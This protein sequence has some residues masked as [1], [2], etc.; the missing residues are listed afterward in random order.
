MLDLLFGRWMQKLVAVSAIFWILTT[1]DLHWDDTRWWCITALIMV[2]DYLSRLDGEHIGVSRILY[3]PREKL[4]RIKDFMDAVDRG[5][6]TSVDEL[7]KILK[8]E[9]KD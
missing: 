2:I 6:E 5:E 3:L 7:N 9:D 4:L 8:K 1:L